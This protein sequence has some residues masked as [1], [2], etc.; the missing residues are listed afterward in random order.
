MLILDVVVLEH[1]DSNQRSGP[2][3]GARLDFGFTGLWGVRVGGDDG[4]F[5]PCH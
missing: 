1:H 4:E 3:R 5:R 2:Q